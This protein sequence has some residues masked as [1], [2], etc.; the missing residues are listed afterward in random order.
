MHNM[1]L[2]RPLG[3]IHV[4]TYIPV[5]TLQHNLLGMYICAQVLTM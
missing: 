2:P 3:D 1:Y 5:G 4:H